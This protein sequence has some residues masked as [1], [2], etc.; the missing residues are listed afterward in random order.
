MR[1]IGIAFGTALALTVSAHADWIGGKWVDVSPFAIPGGNMSGMLGP[2]D[3][4]TGFNSGEGY[5]PGYID[6]QNGWAAFAASA[7]EAHIDTANPFEGDQ[8]LRI[9]GDP[10]IP[11]GTNT[12]AFSPNLGALTPGRSILSVEIAL[13]NWGGSDYDVVPQ[14]PSQGFLTAR[15]KFSWLGDILVLDDVGA[16]LGYQ[17]TGID[18]IEGGYNNLTIDMD[19]VA[20]TI[21]YYYA[22]S[23]IYSSV[24]G[25][26]AGT[27][28]EQ[29]V[30]ISDN[31]QIDDLEYGDFDNLVLTPGPGALALM[32]IV[33]LA[34]V[35][36]RRRRD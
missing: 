11:S 12:G 17:D 15:V 22:D 31:F 1:G 10:G 35:N 25:V 4:S 19:P 5:A 26:Y 32:G 36:R 23:L 29:V 21:D 6:G 20:N 30:L 27:A 3:Y 24:A 9:S 28:M 7:L 8:H 13:S 2:G 18:W 34:G 33:G 14:A 16:G